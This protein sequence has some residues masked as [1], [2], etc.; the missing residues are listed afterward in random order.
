MSTKLLKTLETRHG[1]MLA[2]PNDR[3]ITP[4]LETYGELCPGEWRLL[5]QI[6]RPGMTVVEV[7]SNIGAHT[8][9][10][11]RAC[12]PGPL[13]AFEPQRRVFQILCANLALNDVDNVVARPE[14]C[15]AQAGTAKVPAINYA[16]EG[17]FGGVSLRPPEEAGET[18]R[19][20]RL[21]DLDLGA[22]GLIKVDVEGF[23]GE[24]LAGAAETIAR[25]R[26]VLYVENDRPDRQRALIAQIDAMGY[27]LWW[28]TPALAEPANYKGVNKDIFG[29]RYLSINM[30]CLPKER[31]TQVDLEAIDPADP[32][33][34]S[35]LDPARGPVPG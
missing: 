1:T 17:N 7:G 23:E 18:V 15:G 26:P 6:I 9:G 10:M 13:Y 14:A 5:E 34:P 32:R 35:G 28:H 27:R 25:H 4:C 12:R 16:A 21:D 20:M 19:V 31:A 3:Y 24:V 30:L 8:V 33:M 22:C 11:A 29:V 2:L